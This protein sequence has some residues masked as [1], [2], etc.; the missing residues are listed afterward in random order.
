[1]PFPSPDKT[2]PVTMTYFT[3][4]R[5]C[6]I[7]RVGDKVCVLKSANRRGRVHVAVTHSRMRRAKAYI[8]RTNG[9]ARWFIGDREIRRTS[10]RSGGPGAFTSR[11]CER[12]V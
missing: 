8:D 9:G 6:S 12:D 7:R 4:S 3:Q 2:P 11:C 1:M 10:D 5:E